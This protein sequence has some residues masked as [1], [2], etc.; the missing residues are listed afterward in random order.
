MTRAGEDTRAPKVRSVW[1]AGVLTRAPYQPRMYANIS[2]ATI[3]AS[4]SIT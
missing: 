4:D 2:G 3:D 1:S